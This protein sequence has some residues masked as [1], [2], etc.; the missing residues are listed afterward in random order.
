MTEEQFKELK[1]AFLKQQLEGKKYDE[2]KGCF[3]SNGEELQLDQF[4]TMDLDKKIKI[5]ICRAYEDSQPRTIKGHNSD[6]LFEWSTNPMSVL[7]NSMS[8]FINSEE[9]EKFEKWHEN[10]CENF[11]DEYNEFL[12]GKNC[13]MQA[14]G[15]AQ[16]IINMTLKYLYCMCDCKERFKD[17][18][19][20]I[21]SYTLEWFFRAQ[22]E[23]EEFKSNKYYKS[24]I[25]CWSNMQNG[26]YKK[27]QER[28]RTI[29]E[30]SN[31]YK[32]GGEKMTPFQAEFIIWEEEKIR[33]ALLALTDEKNM[34]YNGSLNDLINNVKDKV[35]DLY[36][37]YNDS[38]C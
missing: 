28:I 15:K 33:S 37:K 8:D 25:G 14:Y 27:I 32:I 11:L 18:H 23:Y 9:C 22:N 17:C 31:N 36:K 1:K 2:G 21:D 10:T 6:G 20:V 26:N 34:V 38:G 29:I 5:A 7:Y 19:M 13:S 24:R 35:E 30:K 4:E 16:K 12:K 3:G